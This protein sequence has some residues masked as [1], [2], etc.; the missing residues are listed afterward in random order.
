MNFDRIIDII[1]NNH[2]VD[3]NLLVEVEKFHEKFPFTSIFPSII[4]K[5]LKSSKNVHFESKLKKY[6]IQV[7]DR[8]VLERYLASEGAKTDTV[9]PK[10]EALVNIE[11][12]EPVA[13]IK[14][15]EK[16]AKKEEIKTKKADSNIEEK[17]IEVKEEEVE[18]KS[19]PKE[20]EK[21]EPIRET[22]KSKKGEEETITPIV[23]L[24]K[25][26]EFTSST[27][28]DPE[29]KRII[30]ELKKKFGEEEEEELKVEPTKTTPEAEIELEEKIE[31]T[32]LEEPDKDFENKVKEEESILIQPKKKDKSK[33]KKKKKAKKDSKK[34][35]DKLADQNTVSPFK[36]KEFKGEDDEYYHLEIDFSDLEPIAVE[37]EEISEETLGNFDF[38][39][40]PEI[41]GIADE[42]NE[43]KVEKIVL[44]EIELEVESSFNS[45]VKI[46]VTEKSELTFM[47]WLKA[48]K[49]SKDQEKRNSQKNTNTKK[50]AMIDKFIEEDPSIGKSKKD[51][52]SPTKNAKL[53][54]EDD[55]E[56][57]S[58]TLAELHV[59]QHNYS[60][61]KK[62]YKKLILKIPEKKS[63]FA[64]KL[65]E[66]STLQKKK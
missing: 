60:K 62:I 50:E 57:V 2:T 41:D 5:G 25:K 48:N 64:K 56:I 35:K 33:K 28:L 10:E 53:S 11:K 21:V 14:E 55:L 31:S 22:E 45:P 52:F 9:K 1:E 43:Q 3:Q 16:E 58:E 42:F 66:I 27:E 24:H 17:E 47:G 61:A 23:E 30:A 54:L 29:T 44:D 12:T 15:L 18:L 38:E 6:A 59:Y 7:N 37:E 20:I 4:L 19:E 32:I 36:F 65:E 49:E 63:L 46:Q 34:I 13:E 8:E 26:E 39:K 40:H 51:F